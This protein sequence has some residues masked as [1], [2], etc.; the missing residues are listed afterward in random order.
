MIALLHAEAR[1]PASK[2]L[3]SEVKAHVNVLE[4]H[5]DGDRPREAIA[6]ALA[7]VFLDAD[8]AI[9]CVRR[10]GV[11]RASRYGFRGSWIGR[12]AKAALGVRDLLAASP[13][14][15]AYLESVEALSR[16]VGN[17]LLLQ[18]EIEATIRSRRAEVLKTVFVIV[19]NLFYHG[20]L[21]DNEAS[22]LSGH[23]YSSEEY[24][25]A[26]SLVLRTYASMFSVDRASFA[27]VDAHAVGKN[28]LVYERLLLAAICLTRFR[29]AELLIDGL[30][31]RADGV[32]ETVTV[33]SIDP[34]IK[35]SIRLG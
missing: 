35:R 2:A 4:R 12:V 31:Y 1:P 16:L 14:R 11:L 8:H 10:E 21:N 20:W 17:A 27:Y 22:S 13:D 34:D 30:P 28:A 33:S 19:N 24:A 6:T 26:A 23:R 15:I 9:A 3:A 18:R 7:M 29:E 5:L 32:G 25:E